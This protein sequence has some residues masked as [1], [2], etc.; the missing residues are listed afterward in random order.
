[1]QRVRRN[2]TYAAFPAF[3][4]SS[5]TAF[6]FGS[7]ITSRLINARS[8]IGYWIVPVLTETLANF[9]EEMHFPLE[10]RCAYQ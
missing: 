9:A 2:A 5:S 4:A 8:A 6:F 1:M 7:S 10:T 3:A